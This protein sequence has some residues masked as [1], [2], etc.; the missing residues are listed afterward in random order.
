MHEQKKTYTF[1]FLKKFSKFHLTNKKKNNLGQ[2]EAY[3]EQEKS[4][5]RVARNENKKPTIY[6]KHQL[7]A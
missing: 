5:Q 6:S 3:S 4:Q 7:S 1:I 2:I